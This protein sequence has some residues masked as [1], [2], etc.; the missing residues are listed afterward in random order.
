MN[1]H[2]LSLSTCLLL[3]L[4]AA[5][6]P[7]DPAGFV[8]IFDGE[9]L[10]GW[11]GNAEFFRVEEQT[12]VAGKALEAIPQ[13]EFICTEQSYSNFELRLEARLNGEGKNAGVQFR[14]TRIPNHHEVIGYQYDMGYAPERP[15][16]ASLYDESRRREFLLQPPASAIQDILHPDDWNEIA[17]R[18]QGPEIHFWLNGHHVLQYTETVDSLPQSGKLCLQ[19]H[20]GA[21]AEARYR[22]IRV[23]ELEPQQ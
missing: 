1:Q 18:C 7:G 23:R 20:S 19:I 14:S 9:T 8:S 4:C 22:N 12:I 5:C 16:W 11:E 15:I 6:S 17:I 10:S 21:P 3:L 2:L 13:N